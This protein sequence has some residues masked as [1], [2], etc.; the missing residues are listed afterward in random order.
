VGDGKSGSAEERRFADASLVLRQFLA[1]PGGDRPR[2]HVIGPVRHV[3]RYNQAFRRVQTG[4]RED[5]ARLKAGLDVT[6]FLMVVD[7]QHLT[8]A[9]RQHGNPM[10]EAGRGQ[11]AVNRDDYG[12]L[13]RIV[14]NPDNVMDSESGSRG[15]PR[16]VVS[17]VIGRVRY[18]VVL[19]ARV[20]RTHIAFLTMFKSWDV[21]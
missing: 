7:D 19:E 6:G 15:G 20:R 5:I 3:A 16:V 13:V 21:Q 8:H 12:C 11:L 2:V 1:A 17:K 9:L 18:K 10:A 14:G 4:E